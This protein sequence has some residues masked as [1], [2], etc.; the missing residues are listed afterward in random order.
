MVSCK[1]T[2]SDYVLPVK[3]SAQ[4]STRGQRFP[5]VHGGSS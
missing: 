2:L 5:V 3:Q 1:V 4:T